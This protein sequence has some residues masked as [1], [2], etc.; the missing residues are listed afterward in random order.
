M[1]GPAGQPEI[2]VWGCGR[3]GSALAR[4]LAVAGQPVVVAT[5]RPGRAATTLAGVPGC[6]ATD[7]DS[8]LRQATMV[9]LALPFPV[10]LHALRGPAGRIG[11]GRTLVDMTNPALGAGQPQNAVLGTGDTLPPS[12]SG[13]ELIAHAASGWRVAK[14]F[15]TLSA[16]ALTHWP[17]DGGPV[18]VPVA[19]DHPSG[20]RE[21][22]ELVLRLGLHPVD[23][24]G[25]ASS[26]EM[27]AMAVLFARISS[28][29]RLRGQIGIHIGR[30]DR[31]A[32]VGEV[33]CPVSR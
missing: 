16:D 17:A 20:R 1:S 6:R 22:F 23:A 30:S 5:G 21:V 27:E 26:R 8:M 29:H 14:A 33:P 24:G 4:A 9:L 15:N 19:S 31:V 10:A 3:M 28:R 11:A 13:G 12:M 2:G 7:P 18:C 32:T 25:I